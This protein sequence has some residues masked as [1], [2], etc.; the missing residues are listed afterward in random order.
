MSCLVYGTD[1]SE[2]IG[3][4]ASSYTGAVVVTMLRGSSRGLWVCSVVWSQE[5]WG[6]I[7]E[8]SV[9]ISNYMERLGEIGQNHKAPADIS[10]HPHHLHNSAG[11]GGVKQ[12]QAWWGSNPTTDILPQESSHCSFLYTAAPQSVTFQRAAGGEAC[13]GTGSLLCRALLAPV[14]FSFVPEVSQPILLRHPDTELQMDALDR[15]SWC[16]NM[17]RNSQLG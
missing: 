13:W 16:H 2:V 17:D 14:C 9:F 8:P 12:N 5:N 15:G 4:I 11:S 6:W 1:G 3:R 7:A 10:M